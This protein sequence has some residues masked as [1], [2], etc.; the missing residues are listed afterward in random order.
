MNP[1]PRTA[2]RRRVVAATTVVGAA[3]LGKSLSATPGSPQFYALS[4]ATGATWAVGALAARPVREQQR[5]KP[6]GTRT[7]TRTGTGG[8]LAPV[9]IGFG[10]FGVFY[11]CALV[12]RHVPVLDRAITEIF[13]YDRVGSSSWVLFTTLANGAAEE[14][15]FRGAL[16]DQLGPRRAVLG[17]TAIYVLVT[18][19]ARNPAL[20]LASTVM[21]TLFGLQRRMTGGTRAPMITHLTWST[22]MLQYLPPLFR[23]TLGGRIPELLTVDQFP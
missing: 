9:L 10:A 20:V 17:S 12:A 6:R 22:L 18:T 2:R 11:G 7:R 8:V 5:R 15:F 1:P 14:A 21:G 13:R 19:A 4:L 3:L 23:P 16:Y